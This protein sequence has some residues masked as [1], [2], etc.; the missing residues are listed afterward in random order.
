MNIKSEVLVNLP[1]KGSCVVTELDVKGVVGAI[2]DATV[3]EGKQKLVILA[4]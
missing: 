2:D 3:T 4:L 1:I